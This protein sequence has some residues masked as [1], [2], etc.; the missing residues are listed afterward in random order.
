MRDFIPLILAALM[1]A[2]SCSSADETIDYRAA[3]QKD[4]KERM[5]RE[6]PVGWHPVLRCPDGTEGANCPKRCEQDKAP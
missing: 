5:A 2:A 3:I 1:L 6:C 4:L